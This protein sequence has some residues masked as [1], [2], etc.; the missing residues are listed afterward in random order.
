M[1]DTAVS[2][3]VRVA[4]WGFLALVV[5]VGVAGVEAWPLT[6]FRLFSFARDDTRTSW[7]ARTVDSEGRET[8]LDQQELPLGYRL[9]AW[10]MSRFPRS[11]RATRDDVCRGL[12]RGARDAGRE[13]A[14]VRIYR[15]RERITRADGEWT[16]VA[17]PER[18]DECGTDVI[19]TVPP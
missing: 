7:E 10:P 4:V 6:A 2:A 13:V 16:V 9:A 11:D 14:E 1:S 17:T 18:Y 12:A 15:I 3:R 8:V 19:G 5:A